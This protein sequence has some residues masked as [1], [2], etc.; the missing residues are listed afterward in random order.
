MVA[1]CA[2]NADTG[3]CACMM[4]YVAGNYWSALTSFIPTIPPL[5]FLTSTA[6]APREDVAMAMEDVP[7]VQA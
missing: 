7:A 6:V 3:C 5:P 1:Q 4:K 2:L